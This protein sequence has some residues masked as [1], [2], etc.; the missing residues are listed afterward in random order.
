MELIQN[1]TSN[2]PNGPFYENQ[3]QIRSELY[4]KNSRG[5]VHSRFSAVLVSVAT[6]GILGLLKIKNRHPTFILEPP[7]TFQ[8]QHMARSHKIES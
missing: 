2:G 3:L 4:L 8:V 7:A 5:P 1:L 6:H